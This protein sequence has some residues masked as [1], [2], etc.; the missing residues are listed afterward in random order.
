MRSFYS[1]ELMTVVRDWEDKAIELRFAY[2]INIHVRGFRSQTHKLSQPMLYLSCR[3]A[4][5]AW[6]DLPFGGVK[7]GHFRLIGIDED[8]YSTI[9]AFENTLHLKVDMQYR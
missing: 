4:R 9:T 5:L 1:R 2:G 3:A 6:L 7:V 8:L